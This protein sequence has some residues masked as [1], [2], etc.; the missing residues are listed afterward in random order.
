MLEYS[1]YILYV[2]LLSIIFSVALWQTI[3]KEVTLYI[4]FILS[5]VV[6]FIGIFYIEG[7]PLPVNIITNAIY[8]NFANSTIHS[9]RLDYGNAIYIFV[10]LPKQSS[11]MVVKLPWNVKDAEQLQKMKK[12]SERNKAQG[13]Q[14]SGDVELDARGSS[15]E[16]RESKFKHKPFNRVLPSKPE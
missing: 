3:F 11:P 4:L 6:G 13:M 5:L 16:N 2:I 1:N 12:Q 14:D 10:T 8:N 9:F 7:K 15:L